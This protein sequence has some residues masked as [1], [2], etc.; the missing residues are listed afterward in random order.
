MPPFQ[1]SGQKKLEKPATS[2]PLTSLKGTSVPET[3]VPT[4]LSDLEE[5][6]RLSKSI[7]SLGHTKIMSNI[8]KLIKN[9]SAPTPPPSNGSKITVADFA[10]YFN[11]TSSAL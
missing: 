6:E 10:R 11:V 5:A 7:A 1:S 2:V 9:A 3:S 8:K 4:N